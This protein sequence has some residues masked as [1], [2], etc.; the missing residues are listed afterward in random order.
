[1]TASVVGSCL[2]FAALGTI[3]AVTP[4]TTDLNAEFQDLVRHRRQ[5][6]QAAA[7]VGRQ[8]QP[9]W[10]MSDLSRMAFI[11]DTALFSQSAGSSTWDWLW[12]SFAD[13]AL[14]PAAA[15]GDAMDLSNAPPAYPRR[16]YRYEVPEPSSLLMWLIL[17]AFGVGYALWR[18]RQLT[19]QIA[20]A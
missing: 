15:P 9:P 10:E 3:D 18:R 2:L 14:L 4:N 13:P 12:D 17:I 16:H 20:G 1:M 5:K 8:D 7:T 19:R 11:G 6:S